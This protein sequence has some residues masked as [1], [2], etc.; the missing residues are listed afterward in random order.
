MAKKKAKRIVTGNRVRQS[1][2]SKQKR[3]KGFLWVFIPIILI[4]AAL[5]AYGHFR[6]RASSSSK[7]SRVE[8]TSR[9]RPVAKLP[10]EPRQKDWDLLAEFDRFV[11]SA[12][13]AA[14]GNEYAE[15]LASFFEQKVVPAQWRGPHTFM[16]LRG[17]PIDNTG[18][19]TTMMFLAAPKDIR[20]LGDLYKGVPFSYGPEGF[21]Y[22]LG[23]K[24]RPWYLGIVGLHEILHWDDVVLS[25]RENP[26]DDQQYL[27]GEVRAHILENKLLDKKMSGRFFRA[28]REML[29][30]ES[31]H[32][33][34]DPY[35][36]LNDE[37]HGYIQSVWPDAPASE[38]E[39]GLR[40]A[41]IMIAVLFEQCSTD[42][43]RAKA[44]D[45]FTQ[46]SYAIGEVD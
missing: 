40:D 31:M 7:T 3:S 28:I 37:G 30:R 19:P 16:T 27:L 2:K 36:V 32:E 1:G 4:V 21:V 33:S 5:M 22:V 20:T 41:S 35:I 34:S 8:R 46:Q 25:Q 10:A 11:E 9:H 23:S 38:S 39:Q 14:K 29:S 6:A 17:S 24:I 26:F 18:N 12:K 43:E 45:W 42:Q 15:H 44:F 13:S